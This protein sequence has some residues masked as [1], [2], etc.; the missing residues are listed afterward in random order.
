MNIA[1]DAI[2]ILGPMSKNRGIGNYALSQF[3][4]MVENDKDNSYF[5][6]NIIEGFDFISKVKTNNIKQFDFYSGENK[7]IIEN[8]EYKEIYGD[9]IKN[10]IKDN[11]IDVFYITSPFE[12]SYTTYEK[13]W[14]LGIKVVSTVYDIIPY[15]LKERYL[16]D[17]K[18]KNW[19]MACV[20]NLRWNDK[21]LV[22]SQSVKDDMIKYLNFQENKIDVIFGAV[23]YHYK[24]IEIDPAIKKEIFNKF[25]IKDKFVMCTGGDDDRKNIAGLI[26][27]YAQMPKELIDEYQLVIVCKLSQQSEYKYNQLVKS[28]NIFG[29]VIFT[30][31]VSTEELIYLYNLAVLMA[32]PSIYEGFGLPVVEAWACGTPVL[33]SNNSSLGEIAGDGAIIVDPYSVSDISRGLVEALS[34]VDLEE[35]LSKGKERL[36][37][38][39]WNRVAD[40]AIKSIN[41]LV[42]EG[43]STEVKNQKIAFFTPLPP[44]QS[45]ISDYSV[46]IIMELSKYFEIDVFIDDGYSPVKL[47]GVQVYNHKEFRKKNKDY[48]DV[49]YQVGNSEY[50]IYMY[51]Y[52]RKVPGTI[53]L[54]DF[55]MH[56]VFQYMALSK[57]KNNLKL[58]SD[59][60]QS[61][62]S[63]SETE[64]YI[65]NLSNG[66]VSLQINQME[67]N[68][69]VVNFANKIIVHSYDSK[70]KLLTR[71]IQRNV[72][73]INHY[74]NIEPLI[75]SG[76]AKRKL[77]IEEK[78]TIM[79]S[80][81]HIHE[82]KRPIPILK[83][84]SKICGEFQDVK[85]I[86]VGKI[87]ASIVTEFNACVEDNKLNGKVIV[88][89]YTE[90]DTF[91]DYIDASDICFNLRYPYNGETSGS[92]MRILAK[93]KCV[94]VNNIGSFGEI[95]DDVCVKLSNVDNV[96]E[97]EEIQEIYNTM[98]KILTDSI[99]RNNIEN[100]A[101]L[102]AEKNLD[103]KLIAKKYRDF[104]LSQ[105]E[106]N[107]T[108]EKLIKISQ[109]EIRDYSN[110]QIYEISKTLVYAK[111]EG[112]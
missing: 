97:Q 34:I 44:V 45:G 1:F 25:D 79:A 11:K 111:G 28:K 73:L 18:T 36:K 43:V 65:K 90:L 104:I 42:P 38:F 46:D 29:R 86:F 96:S 81:G 32:F 39:Q 89:G 24:K 57:G 66:A 31:F 48:F 62:Y 5:F 70:Y 112:N 19:Y 92:L 23:D 30:N 47:E 83:A 58:Y 103:L 21:N 2:A 78:N 100:R 109:S 26:E 77:N 4:S 72:K 67:L 17:K 75:V 53:V 91:T 82:T 107:L 20:E 33:T 6:F 68:G 74:A 51:E 64:E 50:H 56:G 80:F 40:L 55:N 106:S 16:T 99:F 22:I 13:E 41:S 61:D 95:P 110:D 98:K 52:I 69:Y 12:S 54:H 60:I 37:M 3:K 8:K 35:L 76:I 85:Y 93:G 63:K 88:T 27:A 7:F 108:E 87:D 9:I 15:V 49:V 59:I 84:F 10:F 102:F 71:N 14:F 101:R 105:S 94:A